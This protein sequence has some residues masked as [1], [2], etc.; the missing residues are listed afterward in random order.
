MDTF[1]YILVYFIVSAMMWL[2]FWFLL[3]CTLLGLGLPLCALAQIGL[4]YPQQQQMLGVHNQLRQQLGIAPL[5]WSERLANS[6]EQWMLQL[7]TRQACAMRHSNGRGDIGENLFWASPLSWSD[8]ALEVQPVSG[9]EV[10]DSWIIEALD[11]DYASNRCQPGKM[12][13]HY[14]QMVWA[15]SREVGCSRVVCGNYEQLWG[16]QYRPAGN[17]IGQRPY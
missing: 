16:C 12:C 5:V 6:V 8:G 7:A 10:L 1:F 15:R 11:Y 17:Y 3:G 4:S 14:T 13:G 9:R 2:K